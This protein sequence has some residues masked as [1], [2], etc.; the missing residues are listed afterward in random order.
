M[1]ATPPTILRADPRY[2]FRALATLACVTAVG[3]VSI[4]WLLPMV[5]MWLLQERSAGRIPGRAICLGF[6]G[7]VALLALPVSLVGLNVMRMGRRAMEYKQFPPPGTKVIRDSRILRGPHAVT[8]ARAQR[9]L[10]F[11]LVLC[12]L[13]LLGLSSYAA[14][15]VL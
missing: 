13:A 8:L 9:V 12:A 7:L 2:R 10:G 14:S 5:E 3:A 15:V 6:V 11:L 4:G 1:D